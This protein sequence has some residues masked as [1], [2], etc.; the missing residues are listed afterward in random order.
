MRRLSRLLVPYLVG[1][2]APLSAEC[3]RAEVLSVGGGHGFLTDR[4]MARDALRHVAS[5]LERAAADAERSDEEDEEGGQ[6]L[7]REAHAAAAHD[8]EAVSS[9]SRFAGWPGSRAAL[10]SAILV[11]MLAIMAMAMQWR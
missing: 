10:I 3:S 11:L 1:G 2:G 5:F 4:R 8:A 9:R 7:E 6:Q